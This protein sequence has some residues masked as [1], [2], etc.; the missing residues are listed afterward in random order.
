[1]SAPDQAAASQ[2]LMTFKPSCK[3]R[4]VSNAKAIAL[5]AEFSVR[6]SSAEMQVELRNAQVLGAQIGS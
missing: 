6:V 3:I 4:G 5:D 1:M 2:C